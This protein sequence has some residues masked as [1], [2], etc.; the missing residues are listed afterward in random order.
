MFR[1]LLRVAAVIAPA[2]IGGMPALASPAAVTTYHGDAMRTGWN[3]NETALTPAAVGG[4]RFG[5]LTTVALD[6]QVDAEP[7]FAPGLLINGA[8]HATVFVATE[9]DTL[10]AIDAA[11]GAILVTRHFGTPVPM[12]ELPGGC[13]N[14]AANVGINSTPIIDPATQTIYLI[15]YTFETGA[16]VYRLHALDLTTLVDKS[17][18]VVVA[19]SHRLSNGATYNFNPAVTRQ[20]AALLEA[21]GNIYAGFASFCDQAADQSR[22]WVLGWQAAT[23]TPLAGN[24]LIDREA[25]SPDD[26]FLTAIWMSGYGVAA[27]EQ[28][29]LMFVTGNSDY[30]GATYNRTLNLSESVVKLSSDLTQVQS[31]FTPDAPGNDVATLDQSDTDF[32]S[33]GV[34]V[35]PKQPGAHPRMA[36]AAGK[37]GIL[38]LLNRDS[39]GAFHNDGVDHVLD[40][41]DIQGGCW[42][43]PSYYQGAD[44]IGRVV[45]SGGDTAI[46]WKV[47]TKGRTSLIQESAATLINGQDS[48]FF[49]T[50][51]SNGTAAGSQIIWAVSRPIDSDP[52]RIRLYAFD[53]STVDRNTGTMKTLYV[54]AAGSWPNSNAN[55]NIVPM[56]ANGKVFVASY[57]SLAIFGLASGRAI[58]APDAEQAAA[59]IPDGA[60]GHAVSGVVVATPGATEADTLTLKTRTGALAVIDISH[61]RRSSRTALIAGKPL[62]ARGES[63]ADGVVRATAILR[64]KP[65]A[66]LWPADR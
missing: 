24:A 51:S 46:V 12:G 25:R 56:V 37:A 44:G 11:T 15:V 41:V 2:L 27:D 38:Y 23:L 16:P 60:P 55:A 57:R 65:S 14:N 42:C 28:G 48:S 30:N 33:G 10:Y 5:R 63:G 7:L 59:G 36:V 22:G 31:Y 64:L 35:L 61:I 3:A 54:G 49:T 18:A 19:A 40:Q 21:N 29:S 62:M 8:S 50:V 66:A 9:N 52:A 43:G 26:F 4:A 34:M 45:S 39:L 47:N 1:S 53:P 58:A 32:G 20:R 13:S 17:P 6:A